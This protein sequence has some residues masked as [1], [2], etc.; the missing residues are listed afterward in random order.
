VAGDFYDFPA[1]LWFCLAAERLTYWE[2]MSAERLCERFGS[3]RVEL[4]A[5]GA[6]DY[7]DGVAAFIGGVYV[8][9][10]LRRRRH[11]KGLYEALHGLYQKVAL[12]RAKAA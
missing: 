4:D 9:G 10:Q 5:I 11:P 7:P 12:A 6:K 2:H 1:W 3:F 8:A